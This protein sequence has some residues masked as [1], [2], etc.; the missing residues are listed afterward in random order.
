MG[1]VSCVL[2]KCVV[3]M[4]PVEMGSPGKD[5]AGEPLAFRFGH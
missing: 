5:E 3:L 4:L 2:S 1:P